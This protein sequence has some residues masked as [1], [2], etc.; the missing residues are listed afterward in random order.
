MKDVGGP[1]PCSWKGVAEAGRDGAG[2]GTGGEDGRVGGG[3]EGEATWCPSPGSTVVW[4]PDVILRV[5]ELLVCLSTL[6]VSR[7]DN[8]S[9]YT[10]GL[11]CGPCLSYSCC[12]ART[13]CK[14]LTTGY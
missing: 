4:A 12:F 1:S 6:I 10:S 8:L 5:L 7:C 11:R 2:A 14:T 9:R 3:L 13:V